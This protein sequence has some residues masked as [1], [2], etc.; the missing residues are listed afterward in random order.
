MILFDYLYYL[1]FR[2]YSDFN[3]KGAASSSA[4]VIG[5]FQALN[6]LTVMMLFQLVFHQTA[7]INKL[8]V[9][10]MAISFQ[11]FTYY[12][13]TY[14]ES[15]SIDSLETKWLSKTEASRKQISTA[16]FLYGAVSI[17]GCF[18]LA[19]YLGSRHSS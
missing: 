10:V 6:V 3:E 12:R 18:G 4:G 16:L 7:N 11:V 19:I 17:I 5:G 14:K 1:I 8:V 9:L 15:P 2:L 13:Y